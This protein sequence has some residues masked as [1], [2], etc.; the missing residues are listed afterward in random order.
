LGRKNNEAIE[1]L[2]RGIECVDKDDL[3]SAKKL[4]EKTILIDPHYSEAHYCLGLLSLILGNK[5]AAIK[6]CESLESLN[7]NLMKKLANH[8]SDAN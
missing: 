8:I 5:T 2:N 7:H 1:L 4:F 3:D 6:E